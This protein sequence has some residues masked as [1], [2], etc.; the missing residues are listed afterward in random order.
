MYVKVLQRD[1]LRFELITQIPCKPYVM[2][3]NL[4]SSHRKCLDHR[5]LSDDV[6]SDEFLKN[7]LQLL[8]CLFQ[9]LVDFKE[10]FPW[11]KLTSVKLITVIGWQYHWKFWFNTVLWIS[12]FYTIIIIYPTFLSYCYLSKQRS[13]FFQYA[14]FASWYAMFHIAICRLSH[15]KR[16][17]I[18]L[19]YYC[20]CE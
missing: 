14:P 6:T 3:W 2:S 8:H 11:L 5:R 1:E 10:S 7:F 16:W 20:L 19:Q 18:A 17:H 15:G 13:S 4:N 9:N 12:D